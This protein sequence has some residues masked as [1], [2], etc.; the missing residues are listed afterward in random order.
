[1]K[2]LTHWILAL[3]PLV[4]AAGLS[5]AWTG[6]QERPQAEKVAPAQR[7]RGEKQAT[8]KKLV[9][10]LKTSLAEGI[11]LAEKETAGKAF[12][13]GIEIDREGK[14]SIQINL[15]V[16]EKVVI[17]NVDPETKKVTHKDP[18]GADAPARKPGE[19]GK[20][21]KPGKKAGDGQGG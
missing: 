2:N 10:T 14:A 7:P 5:G 8:L 3:V 20:A 11:V 13:A 18:P 17:A 4:S 16:G 19:P 1:M 6:Q 15:F 12:S 21:G 9:P